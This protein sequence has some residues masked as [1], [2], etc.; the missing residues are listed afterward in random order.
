LK[1]LFDQNI[2]PKIVINLEQFFSGSKQVLH[3]GLQ[4]AND[5]VIFEFAR[6]NEFT[7]VTFD[8]DF[9]DLSVVRGFPPKLIWLKTGNL[10]TKHISTLLQQNLDNIQTFLDASEE[11][12]LEI[13]K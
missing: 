7:I 5:S 8:S 12:I 13:L 9:V 11:G 1:L 6:R 2:S 10:T 4:D 3:V